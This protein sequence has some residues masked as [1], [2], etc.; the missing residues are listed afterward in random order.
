M[1]ADDWFRLSGRSNGPGLTHE[2]HHPADCGV[3]ALVDLR[4]RPSH[5]LL[6]DALEMLRN[7]DHRGARGAEE[8]TGDGAGV[9][10]QTPDAF[11]RR[12][13]PPL[14]DVD[15][16][17]V[18]QL[19]LP[20]SE[21]D[22]QLFVAL[23]ER[24]ADANGFDV[25]AW[26]R[27][28]TVNDALGETALDAEPSVQQVFLRPRAACADTEFDRRL[29]LLRRRIERAATELANSD[30]FYVC[31]LDRRT[32]VYKGLL[33]N[34]QLAR[35]YPDLTHP[36]VRSAL[37]VVHARFSTNTLGSWPLAHPYRWIVHN[38]EINTLQG[39]LNWMRAREPDLAHPDFGDEIDDLTPIVDPGQSDTANLDHVL[40]LLMHSGR[41]LPHALRMLMPEAWRQDPAIEDA[42]RDWYAY[43]AML[44]EPWEGPALVAGSDGERVV[45]ALD[46]NGFRPCRFLVTRDDRLALAS[47]AGTLDVDPSHVVE[48]GRLGPGQM[49][50]ADPTRGR[51][52]RDDEVMAE[53]IGDRYGRWVPA[54]RVRLDESQ[55]ISNGRNGHR[56]LSLDP[57]S[58]LAEQRAF[59]YS[60]ESLDRLLG[61]MGKDGKDPVGSMG[62]DAP[63][64]PLAQLAKALFHYFQ[65]SFA[66]V[67]NPA[68]DYVREAGVTSLATFLGPRGNLLDE[69]PDDA[70]RLELDSPVLP[71]A[72]LQQLASMDVT[73]LRA[74]TLEMTFAPDDSLETALDELFQGA[75]DAIAEGRT[76]LV[77]SD[78]DVNAQRA[79]IPSLLATSGLHHHL[80]RRGLRSRVGLIVDSGEAHL[81]HHICA[82]VGYGADAVCPYLAYESLRQSGEDRVER[83]VDALEDGV[84]K[85][86]SKM[87]ISDLESYKGAQIFDAV[88]LD[89][90]FIHRY[91]TGTVSQVGGVGLAE[92]EA[93]V[94]AR[95]RAAF[96]PD[97]DPTRALD[98]GGDY[99]WRRDGEAHAWNPSTVGAL[100]WAA[101]SGHQEAYRRFAEL[102]HD[103]D[104]EHSIRGRLA[105]QTDDTKAVPVD[106][107]EPVASVARRFFGSSMSFG[108]LSREAH[109]TLAIAMNRLGGVACSGEGGEQP[110]RFG[111][112]GECR[113]K[114]V[115]SGRFGV[116]LHYLSNA[117]EIEIKMAQ[118]S[119]PGEGGQLPGH[120]ITDD[121]G[122]VRHTTPGVEL[123]SPPPHHDIYSIEDL[124]Q[125][126]HDLKCANPDAEV[127]V[128]LVARVGVGT[129]AAGVAK[130]RADGILISGDSGGTGASAKTSIK[131]AGLPWELGLAE[132]QQV[133][134][135]QRLRS[136][137]RL[138]VDG[139]LKT[140]RD[141][142]I[143]SLLGAEAFGFGTAPLVALGCVM[144]RKCH[145]NTCS[146]G[147]ATQDPELRARFAG[148]PD[149]VV[150]YLT[151]V[152][153]E[154][155][156]TMA[157][158]GVRSM[159]EL[160]GRVDRLT[161]HS[162][163]DGMDLGPL[164][165]R[166]DSVDAPRKT[167]AQN[168]K[169]DAKRDHELIVQAHPAL[170]RGEPVEVEM[171]ITN[172]DRTF[173]TLLSSRV[174]QR[175]GA[176]G[177][178]EE[179]ITVHLFGTAGQSFGAFGAPGVTLR[180]NGQAN[181]YVGKGL[182]GGKLVIHPP[183]DAGYRPETSVIL[184][185]VAL[186][187]ATS[188][189]LYAR[190]LAG[191]RFAVR[192]SGAFAVVE[193][194]GQH[195]CEYMTGGAI[196]VLG[197]VGQNFA[198][199]MSGG[200]AYL[201]CPDDPLDLE[202]RV[203][204]ERVRMEAIDDP[205][206][207]QLLHRLVENHWAYTGS[208][209]AA[210]LLTFEQLAERFVKV[211][212]TA[213]ADVVEAER[214]KGRDIRPTFPTRAIEP[215]G[216]GVLVGGGK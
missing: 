37:A 27:V 44:T 142:A 176:D 111:T 47:E 66:Q 12:E 199:G 116:T 103:H 31:S 29:Y 73:G 9:L 178:P 71:E 41:S 46:R 26:R 65:Q 96:A 58:L 129:I 167:R 177:L 72:D 28:P 80:I 160:V 174:A 151:G 15:D 188:G 211:M 4:N 170:E 155:R 161:A 97:R 172:Q 23:V 159:D 48:T 7:L 24:V 173:G 51:L 190:G 2:L 57:A 183:T 122:R 117:H 132:T 191:E 198:A 189:E 53:L 67:S 33:T 157:T 153:Q 208:S 86:M 166:P 137:V 210:R 205:R 182:A 70:R 179:A 124:A 90:E 112:D 68:I 186:Y 213:Y 109:E 181:D 85:V 113:N 38:G 216:D 193:G 43:H 30:D 107:V 106:E 78:R 40:E 131:H 79:P 81:V 206:D 146:V 55:P 105:F 99:Y 22:Q 93:D 126:I 158:L 101:R 92:I 165:H 123:I 98:S 76:L 138:R 127:H 187:G 61:P 89:A 201:L 144:L 164:L 215:S 34:D 82:L 54:N 130:A 108:A 87:G 42:R 125:L 69:S 8:N 19:F 17:A 100:Q 49:L 63:P 119:K 145:C 74:H 25:I 209:T 5:G 88:G 148:D 64:A 134:L 212:P 139:G 194:L 16:Y 45:A 13:L 152:A 32:I 1:Q 162:S 18:G 128:K 147:I 14:R 56:G 184:G 20:R 118:G 91:F 150:N 83:Y 77:L 169:L 135:E 114:Q 180:L 50:V 115:A 35:Y 59:G 95:H 120:K 202:R 39:N 110:E 185:N 195:G 140:G 60:A 21:D 121:I 204:R 192:N 36:D 196:V 136:R 10:I 3:G 6:R 104:R 163:E 175:W 11:L 207:R 200:E 102:C 168:H 197:S 52:L 149:H 143:A 94:K 214:Q 133:L 156:E 154:V 171:P 141:V 62:D 75:A 84:L 203:N